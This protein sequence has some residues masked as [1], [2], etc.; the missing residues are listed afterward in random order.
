MDDSSTEESPPIWLLDVDGVLNAD[1]PGWSAAPRSRKLTVPYV[2]PRTGFTTF[3]TFRLRWA[4][5]LITRI[6]QLHAAGRAELRWC[7]TW[8]PEADQLERLW[9]FPPLAR[10]WTEDLYGFRA[11]EAKRA[12]AREVLAAGRRLIWTDDDAFPRTGELVD[13]LTAGGRAL[14]IKP[15]GRR[16]LQ[17]ADMDDIETFTGATS[18]IL[19][20]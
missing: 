4:P 11:V 13:E 20:P 15:D 17:P 18:P 6:K 5:M 3:Q 2:E 10:A 9:G 8:C 16:G 12:A 1:R 14:L 19:A 7:T